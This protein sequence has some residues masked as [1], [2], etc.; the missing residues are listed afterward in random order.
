LNTAPPHS[1]A[2]AL[3]RHRGRFSH[4]LPNLASV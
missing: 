1:V 2:A 3:V 4:P